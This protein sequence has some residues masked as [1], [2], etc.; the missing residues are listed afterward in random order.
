MAISGKMSG[1]GLGAAAPT[2]ARI[3]GRKLLERA[4]E[5]AKD[6]DRLAAICDRRVLAR[7]LLHGRVHVLSPKRRLKCASSRTKSSKRRLAEASSF[8]AQTSSPE[9]P[10]AQ[11]KSARC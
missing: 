8:S 1:S 4:D 10:V 5:I 7:L 6:G 2:R 3:G 9:E 11:R